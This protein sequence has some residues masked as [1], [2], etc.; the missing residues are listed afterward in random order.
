MNNKNFVEAKYTQQK[1]YEY[2]G[3]PLI[4]ALPDIIEDPIHVALALTNYPRYDLEDLSLPAIYR[5]HMVK[6]IKDFFKPLSV[7]YLLEQIISRLVRNGYINRNPFIYNSS[8]PKFDWQKYS[9]Q[10]NAPTVTPQLGIFGISGIGKTSL[11]GKILSLYPQGI[12]HTNYNGDTTIRYQITWLHIETPANC[13]P[14]GLCLSLLSKIDSLFGE[15]LYY[16]KGDSK[17]TSD[18]PDY[19][20]SI[21]DIHSVGLL[22]FD[23]LQNL[24]GIEGKKQEQILNFLVELSNTINV[25][26]ILIGTLKALPLFNTEFRNARRICGDDA[27]IWN[28]IEK[29]EEWDAFVKDLFKFQYT[30]HNVEISD[31]IK[32]LLYY[33]SQGITDIVVKLFMLAQYR[34]ISSG[35]EKITKGIISTV[36]KDCLKP[37]RPIINA[38]K[39]NDIK[40]L[41]NYQD[42]YLSEELWD[43]IIVS[44]ESK[45]ISYSNNVTAKSIN[46]IT[47]LNSKKVAI[48]SWLIQGG[49]NISESES[50]ATEVIKT[51][52]IVTDLN[53]LNRYAYEILMNKKALMHDKDVIDRKKPTKEP[54]GMLVLY[55]KNINTKIPFYNILKESNYIADINEFII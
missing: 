26:I 40:K 17:N 37:V 22:V 21:L 27:I 2:V 29:D 49:F 7:H 11:I 50:T 8:M 53:Q 18:L 1:I 55:E 12:L 28:R 14:K 54:S 30:N 10:N 4:E 31:D 19:I 3:N 45:A 41:E 48:A 51:Y 15:N 42:V 44:E 16:K 38:L 35:K 43:N 20:K 25:P 24:R 32:D 39:S 46:N 6:N 47:M 52:G 36:A 34:A 5:M 23:E 33:E 9:T 13:T